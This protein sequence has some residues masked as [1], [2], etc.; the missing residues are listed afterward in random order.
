MPTQ[1]GGE[2]YLNTSEAMSYLRVSKPTIIELVKDGRLA[3]YK[4][5]I[6]KIHYYKQS[7]LDNLLELR[8]TSPNKP[9]R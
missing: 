9:E 8:R 4:Q 3:Q 2:T 7:D 1:I 6:R 5:G